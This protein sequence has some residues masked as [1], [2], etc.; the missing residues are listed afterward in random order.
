MRHPIRSLSLLAAFPFLLAGLG[1]CDEGKV[2]P[3]EISTYQSYANLS[4]EIKGEKAFPKKELLVLA[5]FG[6]DPSTPITT[7]VIPEPSSANKH[8]SARLGLT[9]N[10]KYLSVAIVTMGATRE[11]VYSFYSYPLSSVPTEDFTVPVTELDLSPFARVQQ[12]VFNANCIACH[13]GSTSAAAGLY[14]TEG[15]SYQALVN[16]AADLS[17]AGKVFVKPGEP[18]ASFLLEV[19]SSDKLRYNHSDIFA[20][21]PE[22]ISLLESWI[23]EGAKK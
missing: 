18:T 5:S 10:E 20:S 15:R 16:V 19:L 4:L 2:Y 6:E 23:E 13:G 11:L 22:Y 12:Q 7:A 1:A 14:L 17:T 8:I 3:E 21:M 9:G